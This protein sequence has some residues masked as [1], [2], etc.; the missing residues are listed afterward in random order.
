MKIHQIL[1]RDPPQPVDSVSK[2]L[3]SNG[4]VGIEIELEGVPR[5]LYR[6]AR[7]KWWK[8]VKDGSLRNDLVSSPTRPA[9]CARTGSRLL[10]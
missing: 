5:E 8:A 6:N 3:V 10:P 9:E 1:E 4:H 2:E 7:Y